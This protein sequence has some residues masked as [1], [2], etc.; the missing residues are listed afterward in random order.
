MRM[1]V[2][3]QVVMGCVDGTMNRQMFYKLMR[4]RLLIVRYQQ[5]MLR[6]LQK[7]DR[8]WLMANYT[9]AVLNTRRGPK[10]RRALAKAEAQLNAQK[11]AK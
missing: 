4:A 6:R 7:L 2:L 1:G 8:P 9:R 3:K 5:E 10:F 11:R